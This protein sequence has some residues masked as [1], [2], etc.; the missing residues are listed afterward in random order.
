MDI[1]F[2]EHYLLKLRQRRFGF[3]ERLLSGTFQALDDYKLIV[4]NFKGLV[5]AEEILKDLFKETYESKIE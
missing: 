1:K 3:S 2:Y 4:G 5:E